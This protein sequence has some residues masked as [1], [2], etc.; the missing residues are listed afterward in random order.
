LINDLDSVL[1]N[2]QPIERE[3]FTSDGRAFLSR[4]L[5]YRTTVD[6][7]SGI[8]LTF[9]EITRR[10]EN[11]AQLRESEE[12][13]RLLIE[14]AT[15]YAIF[16]LAPD[17]SVKTWNKGAERT[18]G[19]SENEIIGESGAILFTPEDRAK[20]VPEQ[21]QRT[22]LEKGRAEDERWH[23][24][25][26]GSRF[27]ASGIMQPLSDR[28]AGFVKIARDMT[29]KLKVQDA[30]RDKE[31]L[32]RLVVALEDERRRIA[33]DMHDELGQQ[34]T[35]LRLKLESLRKDCDNNDLCVRI[36]IIQEIAAHID[37]GVDFL[38]WELRPAALDDLGL[39]AA[40]EKYVA[41]PAGG[42]N[43]SLPDFAG[44]SQQRP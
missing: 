33:R 30:E 7:I 11:E 25:K 26:D 19:Y 15:D 39:F 41:A 17:G 20:D 29:Q 23:I 9:I 36:D 43:Q 16:T 24:R 28:S 4:I 10:K 32:Q 34:L 2:L 18:F 13:L 8:V 12:N 42:R 38:A 40:M 22:A 14:S 3:T 21:E 6:Q 31:M 1:I 5:P 37:N 27:F 44:S 35:A